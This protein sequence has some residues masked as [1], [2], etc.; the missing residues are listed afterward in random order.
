MNN[1]EHGYGMG[2]GWI[3]PLLLVGLVFYFLNIKRED[4]PS[5]KEILDK[6]Y[7]SGEID[8]KEYEEKS[9]ELKK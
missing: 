5:A 7:A 9:Q 3:V 6:R 1:F 4:Q 8:K 2:F